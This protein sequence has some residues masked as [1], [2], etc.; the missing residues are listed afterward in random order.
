MQ[1]AKALDYKKPG[2][3]DPHSNLQARYHASQVSAT[4]EVLQLAHGT[5]W[6]SMLDYTFRRRA[7][8]STIRL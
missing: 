5:T 6:R 4:S 7:R 1:L 8:S 2:F 3:A